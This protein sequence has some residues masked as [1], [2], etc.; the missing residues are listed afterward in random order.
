MADKWFLKQGT[1][2]FELIL[3][4]IDIAVGS[5]STAIFTNFFNRNVGSFLPAKLC[6][7]T[8][9]TTSTVESRWD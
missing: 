1:R 5:G 4:L 9:C 2:Q 8:G 3:L 6:S 7:C